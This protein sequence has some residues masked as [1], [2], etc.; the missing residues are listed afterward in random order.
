MQ[1]VILIDSSSQLYSQVIFIQ[2][3]RK[4]KFQITHMNKKRIN[5]YILIYQGTSSGIL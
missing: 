1:N 4:L 3:K 5:T 2:L